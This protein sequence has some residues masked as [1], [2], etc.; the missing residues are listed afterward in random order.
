[1]LTFLTCIVEVT[2][3]V[4]KEC[5]EDHQSSSIGS[6]PLALEGEAGGRGAESGARGHGGDLGVEGGPPTTHIGQGWGLQ[7]NPAAAS[8][9]H[10]GFHQGRDMVLCAS[11]E[12]G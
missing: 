4:P 8:G 3:P 9:S 12:D 6:V 1:M 5:C 10:R 2:I 7:A 11:I